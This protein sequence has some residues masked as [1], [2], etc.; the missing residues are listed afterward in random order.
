MQEAFLG[1]NAAD[2]NV[3]FNV[4][5][6]G[7][8]SLEEVDPKYLMP[9]FDRLFCCLPE[10]LRQKLR[11]N[12]P[13]RDPEVN[14]LELYTFGLSSENKIIKAKH[15]YTQTSVIRPLFTSISCPIRPKISVCRIHPYTTMLKS[16][17]YSGYCTI[18]IPTYFSSLLGTIF[19]VYSGQ[20]VRYSVWHNCFIL[21][22]TNTVKPQYLQSN[23]WLSK[24]CDCYR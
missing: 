21:I 24:V 1:F 8:M 13:F 16:L 19:A 9:L 23:S 15:I 20:S 5:L 3:K 12:L 11:C 6:T 10:S 18:R 22:K 7:P 14:G 4:V 17:V 2:Y